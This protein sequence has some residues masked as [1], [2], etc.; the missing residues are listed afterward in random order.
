MRRNLEVLRLD[1]LHDFQAAFLRGAARAEGYGKKIRVER[2]QLQARSSKFFHP[3]RRVRRIKFETEK[4]FIHDFLMSCAAAAD[5]AHEK[6]LYK[7][8]PST[9]YQKLS[10]TKSLS[11][12]PTNQNSRQ[13]M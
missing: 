6:I 7:S 4:R 5:S 9:P 12:E 1:L 8:A 11:T 2:R 10:T 13:L 3:F